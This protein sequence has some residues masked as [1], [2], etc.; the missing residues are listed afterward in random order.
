MEGGGQIGQKLVSGHFWPFRPTN[1][2]TFAIFVVSIRR[3]KEVNMSASQKDCHLLTRRSV[4]ERLAVCTRT[5]RGESATTRS[6]RS[7]LSFIKEFTFARMKWTPMS[8]RC[9]AQCLR[10]L[11]EPWPKQS[12]PGAREARPGL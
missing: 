5:S 6:F 10:R 2:K 12:K 11:R 1:Q 3:D 9:L 8:G 7:P 4:A